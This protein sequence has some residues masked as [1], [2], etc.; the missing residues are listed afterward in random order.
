MLETTKKHILKKIANWFRAITGEVYRSK[1]S[2]RGI[3]EAV[4]KQV[5]EEYYDKKGI[6][7]CIKKK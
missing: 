6:R 2:Q 4:I 5:L 7:R 1:M 3:D